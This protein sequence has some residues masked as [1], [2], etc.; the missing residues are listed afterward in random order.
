MTTVSERWRKSTRSAQETNCVEVSNLGAVR[1]SKNPDGP[2]LNAD[3]SG[4]I[5]SVKWG[6]VM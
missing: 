2:R 4:L 5:S 3:L 1:D 6:Q